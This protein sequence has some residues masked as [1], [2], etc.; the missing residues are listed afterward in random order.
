MMNKIENEYC[1]GG[2]HGCQAVVMRTYQGIRA[3]GGD[4]PT[5]FRIALQVLCLR[6]PER[7]AE[8]NTRL[9]SDWIAEALEIADP[10]S[11]H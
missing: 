5:A 4:D 2:C 7:S 8:E 10:A 11:L 3:S 6:H 9:A 1:D